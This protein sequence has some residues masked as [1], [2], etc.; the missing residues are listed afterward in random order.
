MH[1]EVI[2]S[3]MIFQGFFVPPDVIITGITT[4]MDK[5]DVNRVWRIV[6]R[7]SAP[8]HQAK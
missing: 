1:V 8:G 2:R 7:G 5:H 3:T 6:S 4:P